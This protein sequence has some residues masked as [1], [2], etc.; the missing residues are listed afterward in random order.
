MVLDLNAVEPNGGSRSM[1]LLY[2]HRG[3][4]SFGAGFHISDSEAGGAALLLL[5]QCHGTVQNWN[6]VRAGGGENRTDSAEEKDEWTGRA[7]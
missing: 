3:L 7:T 6:W 5:Y 1:S 2:F 4:L